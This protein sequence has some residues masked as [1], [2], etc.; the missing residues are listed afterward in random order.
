MIEEQDQLETR[1]MII[2]F[3]S[4]CYVRFENITDINAIKI[5]LMES[6][7]NSKAFSPSNSTINVVQPNVIE[8]EHTKSSCFLIYYL[9]RNF[10]IFLINFIF[11]KIGN[12]FYTTKSNRTW[13]NLYNCGPGWVKMLWFEP[14]DELEQCGQ[15]DGEW[16]RWFWITSWPSEHVWVS[17]ISEKFKGL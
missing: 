5:S 2:Q 10:V 13:W 6:I 17:Y 7:T 11:R 9:I 16:W 15:S 12:N 4:A 8:I 14:M 3:V 1:P